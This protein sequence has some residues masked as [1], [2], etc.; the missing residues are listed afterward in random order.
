MSATTSEVNELLYYLPSICDTPFWVCVHSLDLRS[1]VYIIFSLFSFSSL[2]D[3]NI[4]F[5]MIPQH[6]TL[7]SQH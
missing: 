7:N 1:F 6:G 4:Y 2:F 3:I 5:R